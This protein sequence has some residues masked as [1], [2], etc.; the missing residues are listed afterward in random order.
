[1]IQREIPSDSYCAYAMRLVAF[2]VIFSLCFVCVFPSSRKR[3]AASFYQPLMKTRRGKAKERQRS[4]GK[5]RVCWSK[6]NATK[7]QMFVCRS[8]PW[9]SEM[10][11]WF[12]QRR[13]SYLPAE[14]I[15]GLFISISGIISPVFWITIRHN[16][17]FVIGLALK[18]QTLVHSVPPI[19]GIV[20]ITQR[21]TGTGL[22]PPHSF[23]SS[24]FTRSLSWV[25]S[26]EFTFTRLFS[27][28]KSLLIS[29]KSW[30]KQ[31]N[32][33]QDF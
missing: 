11:L 5:W 24:F 2:F 13:T 6:N 28:M 17:P 4:R 29:T 32:N 12:Q 31:S 18:H 3:P 14:M 9:R 20:F 21:I 22:P 1:M 27:A 33:L 30:K 16:I 10:Q 15:Q 8:L 25:W 23:I 26:I 7:K 19:S